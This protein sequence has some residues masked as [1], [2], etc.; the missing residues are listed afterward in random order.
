VPRCRPGAVDRV[1]E[2]AAAPFEYL[3][4]LREID[5]PVLACLIA[6]ARACAMPLARNA[7][8]CAAA[9]GHG[10]FMQAQLKI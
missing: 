1:G 6:R 2:I 9:A 4:K 8:S 10:S 7:G 5:R 3:Q